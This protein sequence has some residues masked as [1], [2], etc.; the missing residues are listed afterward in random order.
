MVREEEMGFF[1]H[2]S[3]QMPW[4]LSKNPLRLC[5]PQLT[6]SYL[7]GDYQKN[8]FIYIYTQLLCL[9]SSSKNT[10]PSLSE[11]TCRKQKLH[12]LFQAKWNLIPGTGCSK[13]PWKDWTGKLRNT[14]KTTTELTLPGNFFLLHNQNRGGLEMDNGTLG[15]RSTALAGISQ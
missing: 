11:C 1:S 2:L 15:P 9:P 5:T 12:Y 8:E 6:N 4:I 10:C 3:S 14:K 7:Q 13:Y